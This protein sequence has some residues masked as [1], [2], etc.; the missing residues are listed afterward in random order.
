MAEG[1][2]SVFRNEKKYLV[3]YGKALSIQGKLDE[4]LARDVHSEA[5]R[6]VVRSLCFDLVNNIDYKTQGGGEAQE[7]TA[8]GLFVGCQGV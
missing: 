6:Y 8:P 1:A 4:M 7:D 3:P 5:A 2:L